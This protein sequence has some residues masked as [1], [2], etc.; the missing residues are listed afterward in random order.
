VSPPAG[1]R[2]WSRAAAARGEL[3]AAEAHVRST[4]MA[5]PKTVE[6]LGANSQSL[7]LSGAEASTS[8]VLDALVPAQAIGQPRSSPRR[9]ADRADRVFLNLENCRGLNDATPLAL[10]HVPEGGDPRQYRPP[11]GKQLRCSAWQGDNGHRQPSGH[12]LPSCLRSPT[13]LMPCTSP[14]L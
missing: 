4:A 7:R 12:G 10:H 13:S 3:A 2:N 14:V 9:G 5:R 1:R 6:L 8:V 11:G